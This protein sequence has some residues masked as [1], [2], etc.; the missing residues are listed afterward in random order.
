V[1][2]AL[3]LPRGN[4]PDNALRYW[5]FLTPWIVGGAYGL[6]EGLLVYPGESHL[7]FTLRELA[8]AA[9]SGL[10]LAAALWVWR[11]IER[12]YVGVLLGFAVAWAAHILF[13]SLAFL[14]RYVD[15]SFAEQAAYALAILMLAA[16]AL[17]HE[18]GREPASREARSF[19][20]IQGRR[21]R[22]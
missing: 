20:A 7:N 16:I 1:G 2:M 3:A 12:P 14:G 18:V 11:E 8:H 22:T 4:D 21:V 9:F 13:N 17:A 10:A 6:L 5:L 15:V 19:L